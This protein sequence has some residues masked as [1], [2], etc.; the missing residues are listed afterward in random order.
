[1][2]A[3]VPDFSN[4]APFNDAAA[5]RLDS[6]GRAASEGVYTVI[7]GADMF[8]ELAAL[9]WSFV[10]KGTDTTFHLSGFFGKDIAYF[11]CQGKR[12]NGAILFNGYWRKMVSTET[13]IIHLTIDAAGGASLVLTPG[14]V[15]TRGSI[16][17]SGGY[18]N[19]NEAPGNEFS[20]VYER[21]LNDSPAPFY[22]MAHRSGGRTSDVLPVSENSVEMI[23]KTPEFGS[24]GIEI[25][26]RFTSDGVPVLYHD[27]TL[28][29]RTARKSGL[30]GNIENYSFTQLST[31]IRLIH[32]EKIP[33]L[34]Q[35]LDAVVYQTELRFVW[36]DT[37]FAGPVDEVRAI[38]KEYLQKAA[39]AGRSLKI[40]IGIPGEDQ[41]N[42]FIA[43][44]DYKATP[45][46]CELTTE[47]AE[48]SNALV[49]AS[50]F[51][52]GTQNE[53]VALMH[54]QGRLAFAW[55]LDV[56][57]YI[58]KFIRDGHFD[59]ILSNY[60]TCVAYNYYVHQ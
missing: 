4:W 5:L 20:L 25:D 12:L 38:Q 17:I 15:I 21:K 54:G 29:L 39:A 8:G 16:T 40:V 56:P 33:T 44:P 49:W 2:Q 41:F 52:E 22:I 31:F 50:R 1:Y 53:A 27:N 28:N 45:S 60:P 59:A 46:L 13:G 14:T 7:K 30:T 57:G 36:L 55:T 48:Q 58:T 10:H 47:Q 43:L 26:I 3:P 37:K 42:S 35:A 18:G 9:K 24:T 6:A 34:R 51:T 11:I 19:G 23:M 32:G